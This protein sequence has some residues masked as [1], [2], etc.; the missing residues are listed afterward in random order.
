MRSAITVVV[1]TLSENMKW[2]TIVDA[3]AKDTWERKTCTR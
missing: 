3:H 2:P 1:G